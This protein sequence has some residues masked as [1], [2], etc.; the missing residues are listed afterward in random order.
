MEAEIEKLRAMLHSVAP[1]HNSQAYAGL[2]G[3]GQVLLDQ[4]AEIEKLKKERWK[5]ERE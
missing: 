4:D 5:K 3:T 2:L 1:D